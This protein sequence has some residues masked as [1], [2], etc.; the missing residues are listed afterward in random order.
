MF[1]ISNSPRP[2]SFLAFRG[3]VH[4]DPVRWRGNPLEFP[5]GG[6]GNRYHVGTFYLGGFTATGQVPRLLS[7]RYPYQLLTGESPGNAAIWCPAMAVKPS[8]QQASPVTGWRTNDAS[9]GPTFFHPTNSILTSPPLHRRCR[10]WSEKKN[11]LFHN[12]APLD[13]PPQASKAIR[14]GSRPRPGLARRKL[15]SGCRHQATR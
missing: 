3:C 11:L 12:N 1:S 2:P 7:E 5:E 8:L 15:G 13:T 14:H 9:R 4:S 10:R 6:M